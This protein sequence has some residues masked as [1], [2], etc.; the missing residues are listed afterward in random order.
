MW[1]DQAETTV[2][3]LMGF[4]VQHIS[5]PPQAL[6][7]S[8]NPLRRACSISGRSPISKVNIANLLFRPPSMASRDGS[9]KW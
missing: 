7:D 6:C 1:G 4:I 5:E 2:V 3:P 9:H 8:Y